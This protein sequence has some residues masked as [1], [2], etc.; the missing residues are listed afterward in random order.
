MIFMIKSGTYE[1]KTSEDLLGY[2]GETKARKITVVQPHVNGAAIYRLRIKYSDD[3]AYDIDVTSGT[4]EITG[5][6]LRKA[7]TVSVQWLATTS[8]G[9]NYE[10]V[11]KS[12]VVKMQI[13]SSPNDG[14]APIPPYEKSVEALDMVLSVETQSKENAEKAEAA[15]RSAKE[16]ADNASASAAAAEKSATTA[17]SA[18]STATEKAAEAS[19]AA[20][21]TETNATK[22]QKL[23]N[24]TL[25][26]QQE[27]VAAKDTAVTAKDEAVRAKDGATS[28]A[29]VSQSSAAQAA[30][31]ASEA[32]AAAN[33]ATEKAT[34]A[35]TAAGKAEAAQ[36]AAEA[37]RDTAQ[38]AQADVTAKAEQVATNAAQV[39]SDKTAVET[40][41]AT[42]KNIATL[43]NDYSSPAFIT[44]TA[45]GSNIKLDDSS[46]APIQGLTIYG[47]STQ[48]GTPTP[49]SPIDIISVNNPTITI[50]DNAE[51]T[52]S[53]TIPHILHGLPVSSGG[54]YTD[55]TGKQWVCDTLT[56]NA[57]GNGELIQRVGSEVMNNV[58][59]STIPDATNAFLIKRASSQ[60]GYLEGKA[61]LTQYRLLCSHFSTSEARYTVALNS[62]S[63]SGSPTQQLRAVTT[64][65][66]D[67]L[68]ELFNR[69][70]VVLQYILAA[71]VTTALSPEEVQA[72][73]SL[74]MYFP[75]TNIYNDQSAD[76]SVTYV[77][78]IK[79]YIDN[80]FTELSSAVI[81]S[82]SEKE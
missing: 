8:D 33:T 80:K 40:A 44:P 81:A 51:S 22:T 53:A 75:V 23:Y 26:A 50:S 37:A 1:M 24:D 2:L 56:V 82:A 16:S 55:S 58:V 28:A 32:G 15:A 4:V 11:A 36:T 64:M 21:I 49:E 57:D 48:D 54:N 65:R 17:K 70:N 20:S 12:N 71:P 3:V 30:E 60:K 34:A 68:N 59:A 38:T 35:T 46:N 25:A 52:Q 13:L 69:N 18:A 14:I 5:S 62:M 77:A 29:S 45:D 66:A 72:I 67:A 76:M 73:L 6:V 74:H 19:E 9:V 61:S 42:V 63:W 39:A 78:D 41:E 43:L 7:E 79:T 31:S 10:I 47:R 27:A